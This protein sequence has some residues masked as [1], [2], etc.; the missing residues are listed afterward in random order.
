M[1]AMIVLLMMGRIT[2]VGMVVSAGVGL[3]IIKGG[4]IIML[5]VMGAL[6]VS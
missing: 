4:R 5:G 1:C 3:T 6:H 2:V